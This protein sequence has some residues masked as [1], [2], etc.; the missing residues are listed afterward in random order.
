[1]ILRER[2]FANVVAFFFPF[3]SMFYTF[4]E[5]KSIFVCMS[6]CPSIHLSVHQPVQSRHSG[7]LF[8]CSNVWPVN[9]K[10]HTN[11][12]FAVTWSSDKVDI[13]PLCNSSSLNFRGN[14]IEFISNEMML[15]TLN[16]FFF[17]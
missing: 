8:F 14:K 16:F 7:I 6:I 1:M 13:K 9:R 3:S 17:F 12:C 15:W 2:T 10:L 4:L 5:N 11:F